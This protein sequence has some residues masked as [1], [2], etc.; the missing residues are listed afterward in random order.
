MIVSNCAIYRGG[1]C[2][3]CGYEPSSKE[4]KG[5]GLDFDGTELKEVKPEKKPVAVKTAEELMVSALYMSGR[6]GRTW[7][8]CCG[9]FNGL[10]KKQGTPEYR[11]PDSFHVGGHR[12]KCVRHG[13][14]DSGRRISSLYQF[15]VERGSHG[16][17]LLVPAMA[18]RQPPY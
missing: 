11:I 1:K 3:N 13:S 16:G 9:I 8:Q 10:C 7:R 15:T 5:Q 18:E 2:R 4:R 14:P 6:S 12:Y 17:A